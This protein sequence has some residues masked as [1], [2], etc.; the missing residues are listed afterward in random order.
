MQKQ[1]KKWKNDFILNKI[2]ETISP[3]PNIKQTKRNVKNY[4]PVIIIL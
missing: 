2:R 3:T 1:K 4:S